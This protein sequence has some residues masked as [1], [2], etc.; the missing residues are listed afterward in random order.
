MKRCEL[1]GREKQLKSEFHGHT[2]KMSWLG[3]MHTLRSV[4]LLEDTGVFT[5]LLPKFTTCFFRAHFC[6][7]NSLNEFTSGVLE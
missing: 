1:G 7:T 5:A 6:L 2:V 4:Y 3:A